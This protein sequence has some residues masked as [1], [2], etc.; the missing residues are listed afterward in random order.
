MLLNT[1]LSRSTNC[2][3]Q[4][5]TFCERLDLLTSIGRNWI[6]L[7]KCSLL[8][9]DLGRL[10]HPHDGLGRVHELLLEHTFS[11]ARAVLHLRRHPWCGHNGVPEAQHE[12]PVHPRQWLRYD[13]L[14]KTLSL[15]WL[16]ATNTHGK[17][18]MIKTTKTMDVFARVIDINKDIFIVKFFIQLMFV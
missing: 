12:E 2:H 18:K 17:S 3:C 13:D 4:N 16:L 15:I 8:G 9:K 6:T 1:W 11:E 14:V 5:T 10:L 7:L